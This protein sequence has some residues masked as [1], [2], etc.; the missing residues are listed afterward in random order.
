MFRKNKIPLTI[1]IDD[2]QDTES[3]E[4]QFNVEL[5]SLLKSYYKTDL[6]Q[7]TLP[8]S[9]DRQNLL[10][11]NNTYL[12]QLLDHTERENYMNDTS[13]KY[14]L[15]NPSLMKI[16]EPI[17]VNQENDPISLLN[18]RNF[19]AEFSLLKL[20]TSTQEHKDNEVSLKRSFQRSQNRFSN[21]LPFK[22]NVVPYDECLPENSDPEK[23]YINA[24]YIDGPFVTDEKMFIAAQLPLRGTM[25]KF[26]SMCFTKDIKL[27]IMLCPFT[28]VGRRSYDN[29]LPQQLNEEV[30]LSD[31][32]QIALVSE[33][34]LI[35]NAIIKREILIRKRGAI[36][37]VV[38]LQTIDWPD[39]SVP[40]NESIKA[41]IQAMIESRESFPNSP[42]LTHCSAGVG[43]TGTLIA[44][45]ILLK[46]ISFF[47]C[48]NFD[49]DIPPFFSVF[50][51]VRNLREQRAG[52]V[53]SIEQYKFIYQFI[54]NWI[55]E[56]VTGLRR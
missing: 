48:V 6:I 56:K 13:Y 41:L 4:D 25:N 22:F 15:Q 3:T 45:F 46:C 10:S 53:S 54:L 33:N 18:Q 24:S 40:S 51:T 49:R 43:R 17:F 28:E 32:I 21:M 44:I 36:K 12:K 7:D 16:A 1:T 37:K 38:H 42:I 8:Q 31:D 26:Y 29:Y 23:W 20:I 14:L 39:Y 30:I 34:W 9:K 52:M 47:D 27:I 50:N 19:D 35:P 2:G 11:K 5:E 55:Q